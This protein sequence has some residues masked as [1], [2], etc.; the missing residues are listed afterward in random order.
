MGLS[1]AIPQP[2]G[3]VLLL[4]GPSGAG[5]TMT[6]NAV[7][8]KLGKK[9]LLVNFPVLARAGGSGAATA[10]SVQSIFR[11]AELANAVVFFDECDKPNPNPNPNPNSNRNPNPSAS[12]SPNL[13]RCESLFAKRGHGG[14]SEMT[15]LLTEIERFNGIIFMATNRPQDLD[16]AMF[17]RIR[18]VF[19]L[20]SPHHAQRLQIWR[21]LT[22]AAGIV[23]AE[24]VDLEE[25]SLKS[26]RNLPSPYP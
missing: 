1:Q 3:L 23:L 12:P 8:H 17:R 24:G 19:E 13:S 11:E 14:S 2:D 7:A 16:E 15:E 26:D 18:C 20:A 4:C 9:L 21:R 25:I 6:A 22:S 10:A 5:K